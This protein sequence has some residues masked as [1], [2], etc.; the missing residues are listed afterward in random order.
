MIHDS[1]KGL[2]PFKHGVPLSQDQCSKTFENKYHTKVVSYVCATVAFCMW[3]Y[4]L[5]QIFA[6]L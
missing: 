6:L 5:G 1:K 3:W 4:V 2:L